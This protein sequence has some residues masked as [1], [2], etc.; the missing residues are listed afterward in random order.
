MPVLALREWLCRVAHGSGVLSLDMGTQ[1]PKRCQRAGFGK[2][3]LLTPKC[4][5]NPDRAS[6][7]WSSSTCSLALLWLWLWLYLTLLGKVEKQDKAGG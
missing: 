3:F 5:F 1:P 2:K 6:W 7:H 4:Q